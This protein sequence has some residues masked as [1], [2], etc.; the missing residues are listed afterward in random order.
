MNFDKQRYVGEYLRPR[1]S[2]RELREDDIVD[3]YALSL[4]ASDAE[5][6][7]QLRAVRAYWNTQNPGTRF[8]ALCRLCRTEDQRLRAR[9][10]D[11]MST[12]GWWAERAAAGRK[13]AET[14]IAELAEILVAQFKPFGVVTDNVLAEYAK[15][16]ELRPADGLQAAQQAGLS[17]VAAVELPD[18]PPLASTLTDQLARE[19]AACGAR[20]VPYLLHPGTGPYKL[21]ARFVSLGDPAL[22]LDAVAVREQTAK[23][24]RAGTSAENTARSGALTILTSAVNRGTDLRDVALW[25]LISAVESRTALGATAVRGE[26]IRHGLDEPESAV[27]ALLLIGRRTGGP[28]DARR[29]RKLL[30]EGRLAEARQAA[31]SLPDGLDGKEGARSLVAAAERRLGDLVAEIAAAARAQDEVRALTLLRD[32]AAISRDEADVVLGTL[33]LPPPNGVRLIPDG[34]S[35]RVTWQPGPGHV[36]G[37]TYV[38]TRSEQRHPAGPSDGRELMRGEAT[39]AVDQNCAAARPL[40]YGVFALLAG[41][42][43]SRA[44]A[45]SITLLPRVDRLAADVGPESVTLRW[46][47]HPATERVEVFR[48]AAGSARRVPVPVD[49]ST[50]SVTGLTEGQPLHFEVVAVYRGPDGRECRSDPAQINATPRSEAR[51]VARLRA[52]PVAADGTVKVRVSWTRTDNS[53]VRV[54]RSAAAFEV[55]SGSWLTPPDV[56]RLGTEVTGSRSVAGREVTLEAELPSGVHHLIAL[57]TGG[58][59]TVAGPSAVVAVT[60]PVTGLRATAFADHAVLSWVWPPTSQLA[61]VSWEADGDADVVIVGQARYGAEGG[62]RVP[63]G[64][65]AVPV[66][67]RALIQVGAQRFAA[68]PASITLESPGDT[69]IRYDVRC[70]PSLRGLARRAKRITFVSDEACRAVHVQVVAA[71]GPVQPLSADR[72]VPVLDVRLDLSPRIPIRHDVDVPRAVGRPFWIRAFV[73]GGPGRLVDPPVNQLREG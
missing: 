19:L 29:V 23:A 17:V 33:P 20:T 53:D 44:G 7:A 46:S 37:T 71:H 1:Q 57:S 64:R 62:V 67:V 72:G 3:R 58:T 15:R 27:L 4:P 63:T 68:P 70:A 51:P 28:V 45:A 40:H 54:L 24:E 32:V 66:E 34:D 49:G 52:R 59:G 36:E 13:V 18:A 11:A 35:V 9:Y 5:I 6:A 25:H 60:E 16:L 50:C 41:R 43:H 10:G 56:A 48:T 55:R 14:R 38:V 30:A 21:L 8:A 2:A 31:E 39:H 12:A 26:L 69:T 61:E 22:R 73:M 65:G 47:A 42:P